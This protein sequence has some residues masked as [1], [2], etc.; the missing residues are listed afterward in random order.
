MNMALQFYEAAS[1]FLSLVRIYCY[2]DNMTK[3]AEI[4]NDTGDLAASYHLARQFESKEKTQC[5]Y[6][7]TN[8]Y[9]CI[10]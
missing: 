6:T 8:K 10:C 2:C 5:N 1:D 3:A 7:Y 9:S 4:A